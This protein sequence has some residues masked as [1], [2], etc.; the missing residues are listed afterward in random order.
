MNVGIIEQTAEALYNRDRGG[1][2]TWNDLPADSP[3]RTAYFAGAARFIESIPALNCGDHE[4]HGI[5][6]SWSQSTVAEL[7]DGRCLEYGVRGTR[8]IQS[9]GHELPENCEFEQ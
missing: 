4:Q 2:V 6:A 5:L 7:S 3:T 8:C 1:W 9:E